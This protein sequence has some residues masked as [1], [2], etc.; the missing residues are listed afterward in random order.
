VKSCCIDV[1]LS[2][3]WIESVRTTVATQLADRDEDL[4]DA[5]VMVASEL[6]EN[7]VKYGEPRPG[8]DS[9][10]I[11]LNID[12]QFVRVLSVNGVQAQQRVERLAVIF[13]RL[14][15]APDPL[16]LYM[17]RLQELLANPNQ[18]ETQTGFLRIVCEGQFALSHDYAGGVLTI[19]AERKL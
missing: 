6:A 14:R 19:T 17:Q 2:W 13:E 8:T 11:Q 4:R 18:V 10:Q 5:S 15:T 9:G 1:P 7:V 3:T 12:D 16:Q